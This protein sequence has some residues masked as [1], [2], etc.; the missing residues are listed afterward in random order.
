MIYGIKNSEEAIKFGKNATPEQVAALKEASAIYQYQYMH[1]RDN[2]IS[3]LAE[4]VFN[5]LSMI[6]TQKQLCDE[7]LYEY[8][9]KE[10]NNDK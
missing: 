5:R 10:Q 9:K 4:G 7:A 8:S 6:A 3:I 1:T 2:A